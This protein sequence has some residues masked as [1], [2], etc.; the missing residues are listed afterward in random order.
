MQ[1]SV[2]AEGCLQRWRELRAP[3]ILSPGVD[4]IPRQQDYLSSRPD[5]MDAGLESSR[6]VQTGVALAWPHDWVVEMV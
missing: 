6:L 5:L 2:A 3:T 1:Q 4:G